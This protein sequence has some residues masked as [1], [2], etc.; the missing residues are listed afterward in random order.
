MTTGNSYTP[1]TV[2]SEIG[3]SQN[4]NFSPQEYP[5]IYSDIRALRR[6]IYLLQLALDKYTGSIIYATAVS[7]ITAGQVINISNQSNGDL[8]AYLAQAT[9]KNTQASGI[10]LNSVT[11]GQIVQILTAGIF[12]TD[13]TNLIPGSIY[14]LSN[15]PGV[16]STTPGTI[17]QPIGRALSTSKLLLNI[18][19]LG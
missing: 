1:Q 9:N 12:Q 4:P 3:L 10:A 14:Y 6:S 11:T 7:Q 8:L 19:I 18:P 2:T 5:E 16:Y 13:S 17:N 15:T